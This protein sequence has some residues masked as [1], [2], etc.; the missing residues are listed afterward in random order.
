MGGIGKMIGS[1]FGVPK[2]QSASD[3]ASQQAAAGVSATPP[4]PTATPA[5]PTDPADAAVQQ[6][7]LKKFATAQATGG[8]ASNQL[9]ESRLGDYSQAITRGGALPASR[10]ISGK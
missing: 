7:N 4:T 6:A 10:I 9:T 1:W 8:A 3:I 2:A 5:L